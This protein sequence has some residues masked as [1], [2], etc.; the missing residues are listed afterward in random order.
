MCGNPTLVRHPIRNYEVIPSSLRYGDSQGFTNIAARRK[1][2]RITEGFFSIMHFRRVIKP[3]ESNQ[4][5]KCDVLGIFD[6]TPDFSTEVKGQKSCSV[7]K[8]F[9]KCFKKWDHT[10]SYDFRRYK[11]RTFYVHWLPSRKRK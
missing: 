11:Y 6:F 2:F 4:S 9:R 8:S 10:S 5:P 3:E 7:I 1:I